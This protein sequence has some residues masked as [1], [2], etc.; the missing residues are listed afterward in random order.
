MKT[1]SKMKK[2]LML[3]TLVISFVAVSAF[4]VMANEDG[5][6][7]KK[8]TGVVMKVTSEDGEM[9]SYVLDEMVLNGDFDFEEFVGKEV[10]VTAYVEKDEDGYVF[11]EVQDI[12]LTE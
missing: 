9:V 4:S 11:L 6:T 1:F 8:F 7:V 10:T 3:I 12:T 5:E 2:S